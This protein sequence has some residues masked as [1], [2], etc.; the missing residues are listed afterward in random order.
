MHSNRDLVRL[1]AL[2]YA[3]LL[4]Y[5]AFFNSIDAGVDP[6]A[7]ARPVVAFSDLAQLDWHADYVAPVP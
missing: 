7:R 6:L 4:V 5:L 1:G 3:T 2:S